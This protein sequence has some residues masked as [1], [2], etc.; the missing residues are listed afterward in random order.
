MSVTRRAPPGFVR[1]LLL[2]AL[3]DLLPR[4]IGVRR[5]FAL[6]TRLGGRHTVI[7]DRT[8]T[9]TCAQRI[10][11]CAAFYPRRALCLEQSLALFIV[12]RRRGIRAELKL[13]VQPRPFFAHAWVEVDGQ[14]VNEAEDLP[15]NFA[16]FASLGV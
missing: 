2:V 3:M 16:T 4:V 6:A 15:L 11:L 7:S 1:G 13:G 8:L 12:L 10:A 5:T 9:E 14:P